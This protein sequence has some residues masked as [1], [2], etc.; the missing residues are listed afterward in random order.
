[1]KIDLSNRTA[2]VTGVADGIGKG[3]ATQL[4]SAG[5]HVIIY[6]INGNQA[7]KV[8]DILNE[9]GFKAEYFQGDVSSDADA[10]RA[11]DIIR[12][13]YGKLDILVN[14]AGFNFFKGIEDT[15]VEE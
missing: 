2:L 9:K 7:A 11:A 4:A 8:S 13:K 14:N 6:D 5:A 15:D 12:S 1:M 10:Q 3:C